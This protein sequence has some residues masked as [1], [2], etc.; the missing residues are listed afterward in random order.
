MP[1]S[2]VS[3]LISILDDSASQAQLYALKAIHDLIDR[4]W[5][6]IASYLPR[7]KKFTDTNQNFPDKDLVFSIFSRIHYHLKDTALSFEYATNAGKYFDP[8][9]NTLY[10][11][12]LIEYAI[13]TFLRHSNN[14]HNHRESALNPHISSIILDYAD[15]MVGKGDFSGVIGLA[16]ESSNPQFFMLSLGNCLKAVT[17]KHLKRQIFEIALESSHHAAKDVRPI[18]ARISTFYGVRFGVISPLE[19][20]DLRIK[21]GAAEE[22]TDLLTALISGFEV[23]PYLL[24]KEVELLNNCQK[25]IHK[26]P[27]SE[28]VSV[29]SKEVGSI[30]IRDMNE[31]PNIFS[32]YE[33]FALQ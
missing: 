30:E 16:T 10:S 31:D 15:R 6:E 8:S 28:I 11:Q 27:K 1:L 29:N 26:I 23:N 25:G 4:L 2:S 24:S 9:D 19:Y 5:P 21:N 7:L 13:G 17:E 3:G 32:E 22:L 18:L 12:T 14:V 20:A 33:L